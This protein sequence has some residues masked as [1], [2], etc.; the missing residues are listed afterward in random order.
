VE[1][2]GDEPAPEELRRH[3][4]QLLSPL[5]SLEML[6]RDIFELSA[7]RAGER[8]WSLE[9]VRLKELVVES[10]E[11]MSGQAAQT[12]VALRVSPLE[13]LPP[14]RAN[15]EQLQRVL[16][17]LIT[18]AIRHT[19]EAGTITLSAEARGDSIEVEVADDGEGVRPSDRDRLFDGFRQGGSASGSSSRGG[20]LGLAICRAIVEAHGGRIWFG[21]SPVGTRVCFSLPA[22]VPSAGLAATSSASARGG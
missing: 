2:I 5:E 8:R 11:A 9:N 15:P 18:N 19:P 17:N 21:D 22:A 16:F 10:V 12:E 7:L 4:K 3:A 13:H 6:I 20:G 14:A 1:A